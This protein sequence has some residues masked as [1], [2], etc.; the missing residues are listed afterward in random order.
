[1]NK[2]KKIAI[3]YDGTIATGRYPL[4]GVIDK[5]IARYLKKWKR[6]GHFLILWTCR[7]GRS[8]ELA[9]DYC[10]ENGILFD[11]VNNNVDPSPGVNPRKVFCDFFIDDK[12][13]MPVLDQFKEVDRRLHLG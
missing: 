1:M 8:L 11:A 10:K 6:A 5:Q 4:P 7:E 2:Y 3:D 13:P 9:V 12:C